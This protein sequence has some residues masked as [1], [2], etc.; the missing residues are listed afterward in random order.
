[1]PTT[2]V[3]AGL[4][5]RCLVPDP[6]DYRRFR[7][8]EFAENSFE[9]RCGSMFERIGG[10]PTVDALVDRLYDGIEGDDELR[11]LFGRRL[12]H[13]KA[14]QKVFLAEWLGGPP[15]YSE[16]ATG[17]LVQ[18][19]ADVPITTALADRWLGHVRRALDAAVDDQDDRTVILV[20]ACALARTLVNDQPE[21]RPG[22]AV[23]WCGADARILTR[24]RQLARRGDAD[25]LG[26]TLAQAPDLLG[27][28]FAAAIMQSAV[29]AGRA[30]I[31]RQLVDLGVSPDAA[32]HLPVGAVGIAY[33]RVIFA[34]PL[35]AA[36]LKRRAAAEEVLLAAGAHDDVFTAA[37]LGDLPALEDLLRRDPRLAVA[38][39][40]MVDVLDITPADH[41]VAGGRRAA[42]QLLLEHAGERR[43]SHVRALRAAADHQD[44]A[45][46]GLLLSAGADATRIGVGRWVVHPRLS[47]L[48]TEHGA[49]ID[50]SGA[51]IG[52]ACTGNQ[53]RKDD[54]EFVRALLRH[55]AKA[56]DRRVG[57]PGE[58]AGVGALN[59]TALHYAAKAGFLET[60]KVLL[61]HGA[62][63]DARDSRDRTPL[64]WLDL[65]GPSVSRVA[66]RD[67]LV[68]ARRYG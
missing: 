9:D 14:M 38:S 31:V 64:D 55:G 19:H 57:D 48:L 65:A 61:A 47:L 26:A 36:R 66:V 7:D 28:S 23:A 35:C 18:R 6:P 42:L 1:M 5:H 51:W 53:G 13:G 10:Q 32:F 58:T 20:E 45:M 34:T 40:P 27:P 54:P 21:R 67:L 37:L 46:V 56:T 41:A 62:D 17:G 15:R 25:G 11:P 4:G 29:L 49:A 63:P 30:G 44:E 43:P 39:D 3:P 16:Q 22:V 24:A 68:A 52:A 59:A 33:E 50:S 60:I 8:S 12:A 2:Q